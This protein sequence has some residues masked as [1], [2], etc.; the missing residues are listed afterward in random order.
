M[1]DAET[2]ERFKDYLEANPEHDC[3]AEGCVHGPS[4]YLMVLPSADGAPDGYRVSSETHNITPDAVA[5]SFI[6]AFD[7]SVQDSKPD[8]M[9]ASL[10]WTYGRELIKK[11]AE[12]IEPPGDISSNIAE[13]IHRMMD[14]L[15]GESGE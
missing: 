7:R 2:R 9:P 5:Q 10:A 4:Y 15:R 8:D 6:E 13:F 11:L 3:P 14:D 12:E 1:S